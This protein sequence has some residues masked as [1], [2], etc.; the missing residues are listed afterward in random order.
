[1]DIPR[2]KLS[3]NSRGLSVVIKT[4]SLELRNKSAMRTDTEI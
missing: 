3:K 4:R 2:T 1:M